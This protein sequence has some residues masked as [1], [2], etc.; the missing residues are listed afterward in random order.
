M[1]L[2]KWEQFQNVLDTNTEIIACNW[3][4]RLIFR[5]LGSLNHPINAGHISIQLVRQRGEE[6]LGPL[7]PSEG[8]NLTATKN[9]ISGHAVLVVILLHVNN[10]SVTCVVSNG[11]THP[12]FGRSY[13]ENLGRIMKNVY[14]RWRW[15]FVDLNLKYEV[16]II[17]KWFI[18]S[19]VMGLLFIWLKTKP[20]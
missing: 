9:S 15:S 3:L 5:I 17:D 18:S 8:K 14:D 20:V 1:C 19:L 13:W 2:A 7:C 6:I 11:M 12:L 4:V 10:E 16:R